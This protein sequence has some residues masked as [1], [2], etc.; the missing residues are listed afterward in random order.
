INNDGYDDVLI[1]AP[2]PGSGS[3]V[4]GSGFII[5]GRSSW[6]S[7]IDLS[8]AGGAWDFNKIVGIDTD[9]QAGYSM[10]GVGDANADGALDVL[11]GAYQAD[12]GGRT[13]AGEVYLLSGQAILAANPEPGTM[14]L[15]GLGL[16][17]LGW[18]MKRK[19]KHVSLREQSSASNRKKR[20]ADLRFYRP[21]AG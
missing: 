2:G 21:L 20:R 10:F 18:R 8:G 1:G 7:E 4:P 9:D 19:K 11:I 13:N 5:F 17:G 14:V 6:A 16:A 12:P 15:F 3:T